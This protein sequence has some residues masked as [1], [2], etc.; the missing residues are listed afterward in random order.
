MKFTLFTLPDEKKSFI[1]M[2][3]FDGKKTEKF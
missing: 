3:N 1:P 2:M